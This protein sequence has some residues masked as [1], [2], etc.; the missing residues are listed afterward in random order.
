M[1]NDILPVN[2]CPFLNLASTL[3]DDSN[4]IAYAY[5]VLYHDFWRVM[6]G[7]W[8]SVPVSYF[9]NGIIISK[10]KIFFQGKYFFL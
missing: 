1:D 2:I 6:I 3:Q 10:M 4:E 8:I 5:K 9:I 7:T